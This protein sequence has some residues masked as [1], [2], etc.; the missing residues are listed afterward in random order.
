MLCPQLG[1]DIH[2]PQ[3]INNMDSCYDEMNQI[4]QCCKFNSSTI[5]LNISTLKEQFR[6]KFGA[7]IH[8]P[9]RMKPSRNHYHQSF[10]HAE[11]GE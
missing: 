2:S 6:F 4:M 1:T 8:D 5:Q 7:Y 3:K 9:Q 10:S 11:S